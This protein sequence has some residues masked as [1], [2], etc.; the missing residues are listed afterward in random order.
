MASQTYSE[1]N[2]TALDL[3]REISLKKIKIDTDAK[4]EAINK[5]LDKENYM[6]KGFWAQYDYHNQALLIYEGKRVREKIP[7]A[8]LKSILDKEDEYSGKYCGVIK[9]WYGILRSFVYTY[10]L[11]KLDAKKATAVNQSNYKQILELDA[12]AEELIAD[13]DE[14]YTDIKKE[15]LASQYKEEGERLDRLYEILYIELEDTIIK[16]GDIEIKAFEVENIAELEEG[17]YKTSKGFFEDMNS[18]LEL[19]KKAEGVTHTIPNGE[20]YNNEQIKAQG[21]M[22]ME[23]NGTDIEL[24]AEIVRKGS[25]DEFYWNILAKPIELSTKEFLEKIWDKISDYDNP[26]DERC[27]LKLSSEDKTKNFK[28]FYNPKILGNQVLFKGPPCTLKQTIPE[29]LSAIL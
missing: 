5:K 29:V 2:N 16:M 20:S 3:N 21:T 22:N 27:N 17:A 10:K 26:L 28:L 15:E 1:I 7:Y 13:F 19:I 12:E 9:E 14:N 11:N 4:I 8:T 23:I 18:A 24:K 25:E 6:F